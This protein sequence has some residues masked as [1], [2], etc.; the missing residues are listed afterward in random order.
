MPTE[1]QQGHRHLRPRNL[2]GAERSAFRTPVSKTHADAPNQQRLR[3]G[4]DPRD[5]QTSEF[6]LF[7][8]FVER[9]IWLIPSA[10]IFSD[11]LA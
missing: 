1:K 2:P 4:F 9:L 6:K 11:M 10:H 7:V 5:F 8:V 3:R